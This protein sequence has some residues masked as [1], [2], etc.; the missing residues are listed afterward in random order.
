[1]A[2]WFYTKVSKELVEEFETF[3][4]ILNRNINSDEFACFKAYHLVNEN[5]HE[6]EYYLFET[7]NYIRDFITFSYPIESCNE[8]NILALQLI[9]FENK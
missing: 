5:N 6:K 7:S 1:M 8:P 4:Q 3:L 9:K 2:N